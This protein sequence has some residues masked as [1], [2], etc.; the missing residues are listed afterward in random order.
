M[1]TLIMAIIAM[2]ITLGG[3]ILAW[4]AGRKKKQPA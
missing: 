4:F 1:D 3:V 2:F